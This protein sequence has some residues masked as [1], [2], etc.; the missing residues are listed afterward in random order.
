MDWVYPSFKRAVPEHTKY[1]HFY[2][3]PTESNVLLPS[4]SEMLSK[5]SPDSDNIGLIRWRKKEGEQV[6]N[7]ISREAMYEGTQSHEAMEKYLNNKPV[8]HLSLPVRAHFTQLADLVQDVQ[9][10][11]T[12]EIE[13][14]SE[15]MGIGGTCDGV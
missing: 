3:T 11:Y 14:Y 7:H 12:T 15:T 10:V 9:S 6:A 2:R 4:V 5:T 1:K 8:G 13:L